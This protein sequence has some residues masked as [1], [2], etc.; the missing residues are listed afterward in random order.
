MPSLQCNSVLENCVGSFVFVAKRNLVSCG[1]TQVQKDIYWAFNKL[2]I[3]TKKQARNI[4]HN[5]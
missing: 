2:D 1:F 3:I 4:K 5:H